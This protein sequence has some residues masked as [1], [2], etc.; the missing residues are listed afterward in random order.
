[1]RKFVVINNQ[2]VNLDN[3]IWTRFRPDGYKKGPRLDLIV[4]TSLDE[5]Q[6]TITHELVLIGDEAETL[7][8]YI[9]RTAE[10]VNQQL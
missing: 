10:W 7:W 2:A 3:V 8:N 4:G 1:M 5:G 9:G 6:T